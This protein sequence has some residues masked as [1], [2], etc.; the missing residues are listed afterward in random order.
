MK[1]CRFLLSL[2]MKTKVFLFPLYLKKKSMSNSVVLNSESFAAAADA[3]RTRCSVPVLIVLAE[4]HNAT[5][6]TPPN[7]AFKVPETSLLCAVAKPVLEG[8]RRYL[9]EPN[10]APLFW[11]SW[12][13]GGKEPVS[14]TTPIGLVAQLK[15]HEFDREDALAAAAATTKIAT[16]ATLNFDDSSS[17]KKSHVIFPIKLF[18]NFRVTKRGEIFPFHASHMT[19]SQFVTAMNDNVLHSVKRSVAIMNSDSYKTFLGKLNPTDMEALYDLCLMDSVSL[20]KRTALARFHRDIL[21][22]VDVRNWPI[23][24]HSMESGRTMSLAIPAK[25]EKNSIL[26]NN[27]STNN[28]N[29][30]KNADDSEHASGN[31]NDDDQQ[32]QVGSP[33]VIMGIQGQF[34]TH[35]KKKTPSP[36]T[37]QQQKNK[38]PEEENSAASNLNLRPTVFN[39]VVAV[40]FEKMSQNHLDKEGR[41]SR[42]AAMDCLRRRLLVGGL[43]EAPLA[44][45]PLRWLMEHVVSADLALHIL[46]LPPIV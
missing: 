33:V 6:T 37:S 16:S 13:N 24:I 30:N 40:I 2:E 25:V 19:G 7:L 18:A 36:A 22:T 10:N 41:N 4:D 39:D 45:T 20:T 28:N 11:L 27:N 32:Q 42:D 12:E 1:L 5:D 46:L 43:P 9:P 21:A 29:N 38:N 3:F 44:E 14:W 31:D 34:M 8:F 17:K 15:Q 35:Q 26:S 23:M